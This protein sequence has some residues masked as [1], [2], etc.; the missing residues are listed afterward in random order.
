KTTNN[1][2]STGSLSSRFELIDT[3][4]SQAYKLNEITKTSL[5]TS[6]NKSWADIT[7]QENP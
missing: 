2:D 6:D 1:E 7:E 4:T 3:N 5:Q